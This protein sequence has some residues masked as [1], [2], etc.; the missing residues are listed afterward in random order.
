MAIVLKLFYR[1]VTVGL[2]VTL[3]NPACIKAFDTSYCELRHHWSFLQCIQKRCRSTSS[4]VL[5]VSKWPVVNSQALAFLWPLP[6]A[7][8]PREHEHQGESDCCNVQ[9]EEDSVY[10]RG[11]DPPLH[12]LWV[13]LVVFV[14]SFKMSRWLSK[15]ATVVLF[16]HGDAVRRGR[17]RGLSWRGY[18]I[19]LCAK[20]LRQTSDKD[21]KH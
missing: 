3:L 11:N 7:A 1:S 8:L 21:L 12:V 19:R 4:V 20:D 18:Q 9:E 10:N 2:E 13:S 6:G 5:W 15:C 17:F 16:Y 14:S